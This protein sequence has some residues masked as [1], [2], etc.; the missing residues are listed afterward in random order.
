M[1]E[2][3]APQLGELDAGEAA[4]ALDLQERVAEAARFRAVL[5]IAMPLWVASGVLDWVT[6]TYTLP[7]SVV[8]LWLLRASPL[9]PGLF[10]YLRL[11]SPSPP[12]PRVLQLISFSCFVMPAG[13][14]SVM[15][16]HYWGIRSPYGHGVLCVI[17]AYSTAMPRSWRASWPFYL[18]LLTIFPLTMGLASVIDPVVEAQLASAEDRIQLIQ[19]MLAATVAVGLSLLAGHLH[20]RLRREMLE[21]RQRSRY[22]LLRK[23][24]SGGMGEVWCA[25]HPGLRREVALKILR[26]SGNAEAVAR[27]AREIKATRALGHPNT[28]RILDCGVTDEDL[29]YYSMELLEGQTLAQVVAQTGP[30][31]PARAVHL[32]L[33]A[34]RAI[35]EAHTEGILHRDVKPENVFVTARGGEHD[36]IKV[37]DFGIAGLVR[38]NQ[39][40]TREGTL[41]GT[42]RWMSPEQELG[43]Q[44]DA[45]SDVYGLGAVLYFMLSARPPVDGVSLMAL[46]RARDHDGI[47]L[48]STMNPA[49]SPA[50]DA[51]VQRCLHKSAD[52]RFADAGELARALWNLGLHHGHVGEPLPPAPPDVDLQRTPTLA[53]G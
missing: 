52:A 53:S 17:V 19:L 24:G 41:V 31:P 25:W 33:Q 46:I 1:L 3:L 47:P 35:A 49:V 42:L 45:R 51:L 26:E 10:A 32:A 30:M 22:E 39:Q 15:A 36:V 14:L 8:W 5:A 48:A 23:L 38:S 20:A 18:A 12:G 27:F 29:W 21:S 6:A 34:A 7:Q 37:L 9:V 28:V 43:L 13:A 40:L 50:L 11:R 2:V 4:K 16:L 44:A